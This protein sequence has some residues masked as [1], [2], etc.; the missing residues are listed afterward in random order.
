MEAKILPQGYI[1]LPDEVLRRLG[2]ETGTRLHVDFDEQTGCI[3][4][5]R[6]SNPKYSFVYWQ[7]G[8]SKVKPATRRKPLSK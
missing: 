8:K 5:R 3:Y 7:R 4:L 2:L 1:V 6:I